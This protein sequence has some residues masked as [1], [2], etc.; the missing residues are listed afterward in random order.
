M[1]PSDY[2]NVI[3]DSFTGAIVAIEGIRDAAVLLN[4]P[5]GCKFY[6]GAVSE[7]QMP[8]ADFLDPLY[9]SEEFYFGQP[10]VPVTF[11]D[12]YDYVFGATD[13]LEKILPVVAQKGHGLIGVI[14]SPGAALIGDDL[15]R[16]IEN[17]DLPVPCIAIENTGFSQPLA[18][19][20]QHAVMDVLT[21]ISTQR[22]P[23]KKGFIN[24]MGISI[25]HHH[26]Q[27]NVAELTTLLEA[28]GI[29]VN[30]TICAGCTLSD[31]ENMA[32]A[33]LNVVVHA[34]YVDELVPFMA[35]RFGIKSLVP[36]GG[37]PVGFK[38]TES[39]ISGVCQQLDVNP[40]PAL[41]LIKC[42]RQKSHGAL[43]RFNALT[44][45]PKGATFAVDADASLALPLVTWLYEYLGMVPVSIR[46][47]TGMPESVDK[48]KSFLHKIHCAG[49]WQADTGHG[50][51]DVVFGSG[52]VIARLRLSGRP[53]TGIE[54][55]MPAGTYQHVIP[56]TYM[57]PQGGLY[58]IE[59]IINGLAGCS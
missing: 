36:P 13:K 26:W 6:H 53:F 38:A 11:L 41:G 43:N 57:G 19:G 16:F 23:L 55:S 34:E 14:N 52:A 58:L 2:S 4:G 35:E 25:F 18:S 28:C 59:R 3:P 33:Q 56:K 15:L 5:T 54:L 42:A 9:Y 22:P 12:D 49:A 20:F 17:A 10:R 44:G 50:S 45:L 40:A 8:R 37:A 47:N 29:M 32:A 21:T 27:G 31:L 24:L 48:I 39:W 46:V 30:T 1:T 7:S 51:P